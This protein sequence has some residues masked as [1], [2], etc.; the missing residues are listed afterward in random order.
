M[1]NYSL[2]TAVLVLLLASFTQVVNAQVK[3]FTFNKVSRDIK[4]EA[5]K[6]E[7]QGYKTFPGGMP[8]AQQLNGSFSKQNEV[9]QDGY[10]RWI[11]ASGSSVGETQAAAENAA[12]QIAIVNLAKLVESNIRSVIETD[13]ANNQINSEE[14]TSITKVVSVSVD[15]VA[16]KVGMVTPIFKV[17]RPIEK[18]TEVQIMVGYNYELVK[19]QLMDEMRA[20]LQQEAVDVREK[21]E[22]WLNQDPMN[23]GAIRNFSGDEPAKP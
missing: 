21:N 17:Y 5:R 12:V 19:K 2:T 4:K 16:K 20:E 9:D 13:L 22:K 7:K 10:P 3:K 11:I 15:K 23:R 14:A 1:K 18:N 8:I 6:Y